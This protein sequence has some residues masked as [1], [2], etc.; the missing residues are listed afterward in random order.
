MLKVT[1]IEFIFRAIP[2]A[3]IYIFAMY[4]F[5]G[6]KIDKVRYIKTSIILAIMMCT[7]RSLPISY[8]VHTIL[9]IMIAITLCGTINKLAII[10]IIHASIISVVIQFLAEGIDILLIEAV[11]K[12]N[13]HEVLKNPLHKVIYGIPSLV[14]WGA[15]IFIY[16]QYISKKVKKSND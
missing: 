12:K 4:V 3:F 10:D 16:Y 15:A 2:E 11:F 6:A 1:L 13:I 7:I 14:M 8:G 5:A 9:I